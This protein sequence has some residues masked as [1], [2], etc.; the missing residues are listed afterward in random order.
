ML[1]LQRLPRSAGVLTGA[2]FLEALRAISRFRHQN[3]QLPLLHLVGEGGRRDEGQKCAGMQKISHLSQ[4]IH[5]CC[6]SDY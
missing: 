1:D 4:E 2:G 6:V 5:R 3:T